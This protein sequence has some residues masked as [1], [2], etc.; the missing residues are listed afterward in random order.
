MGCGNRKKSRG[1]AL[2]PRLF[3]EVCVRDGWAGWPSVRKK[4]L[5]MF[6]FFF[7]FFFFFSV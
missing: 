5:F 7:A 3:A 2:Q 4:A 6:T 1:R